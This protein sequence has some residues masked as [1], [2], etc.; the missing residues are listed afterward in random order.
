M[1]KNLSNRKR[2]RYLKFN[3]ILFFL[4]IMIF[5]LFFSYWSV[6]KEKIVNY[7]IIF[8]ENI[9]NKYQYTLKEVKIEGIE[10]IKVSEIQDF[11]SLYMNKSIF[12]IPIHKISS[13]VSK[14]NWVKSVKIKSDYKSTIVVLIEESKP[15]GIFDNA[16]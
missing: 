13:K 10:F 2:V 6:G 14:D 3:K 12:L 7:F 5:L 11:F 8:I 15:F 1:I 4:T 16:F 9:S